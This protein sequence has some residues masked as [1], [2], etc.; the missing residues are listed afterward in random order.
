MSLFNFENLR[1]RVLL[2]FKYNHER[3]YATAN[4]KIVKKSVVS[5]KD[6]QKMIILLRL[7]LKY[8]PETETNFKRD[9]ILRRLDSRQ[10]ELRMKDRSLLECQKSS[11]RKHNKWKCFFI[12]F[13]YSSGSFCTLRKIIKTDKMKR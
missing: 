6:K 1:L 7:Q 5:R 3:V 4:G 12:P 13:P 10:S 2:S 11:R 8:L 9:L